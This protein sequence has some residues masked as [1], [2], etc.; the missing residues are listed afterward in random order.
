MSMNDIEKEIEKIR[1]ELAVT[2]PEE[3][4]NSRYSGDILECSE[5]SEILTRQNL[6][7]LRLV[8]LNK[9]LSAA[10]SIDVNK[11]SRTAVGIGSVVTLSCIRTNNNRVLKL[12]SGE[13]HDIVS[14]QTFCEEVTLHS[15]I[16]KAVFN[17]TVGDTVIVN[18]P[19][20]IFQ[21]TIIS[22][23]TIHNIK[24]HS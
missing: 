21:Y 9:R 19:N 8:Q 20:G 5:Y 23:V 13:I 1:Y 15:P 17:K 22:L 11:I 6:L 18:T 14:D 2:I 24:S 7:S 12:I 10:N 16:G 4:Q 3:L